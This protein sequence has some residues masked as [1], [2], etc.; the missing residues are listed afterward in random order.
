MSTNEDSTNTPLHIAA[1]EGQKERAAELISQGAGVNARNRAAETPLH[2][3]AYFGQVEVA[4]L[5][6][7]H[8]AD[9]NAKN[10]GGSTPL[11]D[12][13]IKGHKA[14]TELLVAHGADVNAPDNERMT[15]LHRAAFEGY[16]EVA[17]VL[18]AAGADLNARDKNGETPF[19]A[20]QYTPRG[21][22]LTE[23][24]RQRGS[25]RK[26]GC[27][28]ATAVYGSPLANE[29]STLIEFRDLV[30]SQT[31]LGRYF[32]QFY[33][34]ASPPLADFAS[35]H[36]CVRRVVRTWFLAPLLR[37]VSRRLG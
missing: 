22:E 8:G 18:I 1:Q 7:D 33:Y 34:W 15:P 37:V 25:T 21:K 13:A 2:C 3:A 14:M 4:K 5:L 35:S 20:S 24:L 28:I 29:V 11:L 30:L 26:S 19:D 36:A 27:F 16:R 10:G 12:A 17:E 9:V 31:S 23:L 32:I 6:I